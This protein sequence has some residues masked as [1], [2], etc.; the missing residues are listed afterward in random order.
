MLDREGRIH[1]LSHAIG[2]EIGDLRSTGVTPADVGAVAAGSTLGL[3]QQLLANAGQVGLNVLAVGYVTD[4][5]V[6]GVSLGAGNVVQVYASGADFTAGNVLYREFMSFGE[7]ICFTGLV[8]GAIIT[9]TA[10]FY[11]FSEVDLGGAFLASMPLLSYGLSF[12]GSFLFA[13]R[14][15]ERTT[16]NHAFVFVV[17]GPLES[18]VQVTFGNGD[19]ITDQPAQTLAP[20]EFAAIYLDGNT[21]YSINGS[22]PIMVCTASGFDNSDFTSD[23]T[24]AGAGPRDARVAMPLSADVITHPRSGQMSAPFPNTPVDWFSVKNTQGSFLVSPG[25]PV[26]I[27]TETGLFATDYRPGDFA[28]FRA[29]G[30][31]IGNSGADNAGGDATPACPVSAM[32]QVVAQP[33]FVADSGAGAQSSI[34]IAGPHVGTAQVWEWNDVTLQLDLAYTVPLNRQGVTVTSGEDQFHPVAGQVANEPD[35]GVVSLVGLLRPGVVTADVPIMVIVQSASVNTTVIRSQNGTTTAGARS[36]NDET[37]M[38]GIT[39]DRVAFEGREDAN[40]ILRKR[41]LDA[42]GGESWVVA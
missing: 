3:E 18:V 26:N 31:V 6:Q 21:E 8:N 40:G 4:G 2:L 12:T 28:R 36:Q 9:S 1:E 19:P 23:R 29:T 41:V 32:S 33:L 7:P 38:F 35:T 39:P 13:F 30:L 14:E 11:G 25:S 22:N 16:D 15:A 17:N 24:P 5:K 37:L 34:T 27:Q 42:V 20:W 10:G